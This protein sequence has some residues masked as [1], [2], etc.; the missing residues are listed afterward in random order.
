M[1]ELGGTGIA[2]IFR[3][4]DPGPT[5]CIRCELDALPI[6]EINT[7]EHASVIHNVSHKCGH[8]GHMAIVAGLAEI[9]DK[10]P[11]EQG[12]VVLLFQPAEE[13]GEGAKAILQDKRFEKIRPDYII[14]L[15]NLPGLVKHEIFCKTGTFTPA[16]NS[17]VIYLDGKTSHAA[18]PEKGIN[19]SLAIAEIIAETRK[20]E[21]T[22][23]ASPDFALI[24][25]IHIEMGEI[26]YGISAG[27]GVVRLTL[28]TWNNDNLEKLSTRVAAISEEMAVKHQLSIKTE[29]TQFFS[30]NINEASVVETIKK[31]AE[32]NQFVYTERTEPFRWGED[33]GLFTDSYKGA[34][35]GIGSGET[36][37]ALHNPD[38]D[39]PDDIIPTGIQMFYSIIR[40]ILSTKNV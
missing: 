37:P 24:T 16:V 17:I 25:P 30:A 27:H 35:F 21:N 34:M 4:K 6:K 29:W 7:F 22:N 12:T 13:N 28:R 3:G 15:H 23:T 39:F 38:Y 20:L 11:P 19:P 9:L 26:A 31:A 5:V 14:A 8:D 40:Q 18:E 36:T 32:E 33:F 2:A 1:E 10:H